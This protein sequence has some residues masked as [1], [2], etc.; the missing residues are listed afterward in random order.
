[1]LEALNNLRNNLGFKFQNDRSKLSLIKF[2]KTT[3]FLKTFV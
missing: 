1:M 3:H 2:A